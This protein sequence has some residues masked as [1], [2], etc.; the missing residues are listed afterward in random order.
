MAA[1]RAGDRTVNRLWALDGGTLNQDMSLMMLGLQPG[2]L[3]MPVPMFLVEHDRGLLLYDSGMAP[4]AAEDPE[5]TY[6]PL[7]EFMGLE[8]TPE[9]RVDR[10]LQSLGLSCADI[11]HV[12]LSHPHWDHAGGLH[13]FPQA[14]LYAGAADL[15]FALWPHTPAFEAHF[16]REDIELTRGFD[17]HP[18][19]G[20]HDVFGDG[21]VTI[22]ST[23]GHTPGHQSLLLTTDNGPLLLT[24]DAV[25]L[26]VG[27][28]QLLP[29]G[30]DWSTEHAVRSIRRL[31]TVAEALDARVWVNHDP[32]DWA[33]FG[34]GGEV[35]L[36]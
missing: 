19:D 31:R 34:G 15:P 36:P 27:L 13:L 6:G 1:V 14:K 12:V 35:K 10:Q 2:P 25:H 3:A 7:L 8:L 11:T 23:P 33:R 29:S 5:G 32:T 30:W 9:Q 21:S 28:E 16:R 18:L 24:G 26:Q 20:D 17:W 4:G 22:L